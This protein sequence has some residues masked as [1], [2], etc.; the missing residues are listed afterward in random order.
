MITL[1]GIKNCDS[2][3][4]ARKFFDAREI[5]YT[6][7]DFDQT[8]ATCEQIDGWLTHV[9]TAVL[10]NGRST[11]CRTL[12]LKAKA[13]SDAQKR[14]WLCKENR[15]IKRPVVT[16]GVKVLVG[17]DPQLYEGAFSHV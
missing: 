11:T 13:L 1:Y 4:K 15:L 12:G 8:P 2:V 17:F 5:P 16:D 9:D 3:R 6:F 10:F 14:D 7:F